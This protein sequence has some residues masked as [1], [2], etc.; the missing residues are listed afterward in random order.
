MTRPGTPGD[1]IRLRAEAL[2]VDDAPRDAGRSSFRRDTPER[3]TPT[4]EKL[5]IE[6]P[7]EPFPQL[8]D[9]APGFSTSVDEMSPHMW[10]TRALPAPR[11][12]AARLHLGGPFRLGGPFAV[13]DR[14]VLADCLLW[15]RRKGF[16]GRRAPWRH[17][18]RNGGAC[19][20]DG[21]LRSATEALASAFARR[22]Q[23]AL[24]GPN[25]CRRRGGESF[26]PPVGRP[27][28]PGWCGKEGDKSATRRICMHSFSTGK[29]RQS[30]GRITR[31]S[32]IT[33]T[34]ALVV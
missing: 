26:Q 4:R 15:R 16:R 5:P 34:Q 24:A 25:L 22:L 2:T 18:V 28:A 14:F 13:T 27:E 10:K 17:R 20:G 3:D 29:G 6:E 32:L 9:N 21:G 8:V 23:G 11:K 1:R 30:T 19:V 7:E 31:V 12:A 33:R